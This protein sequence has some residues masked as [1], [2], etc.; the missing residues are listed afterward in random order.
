MEELTEDSPHGF[1]VLPA[2]L[3]LPASKNQVVENHLPATNKK[4]GGRK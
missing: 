4:L 2:A 3:D 1:E